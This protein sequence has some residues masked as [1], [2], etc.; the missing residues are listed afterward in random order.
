MDEYDEVIAQYSDNLSL[1]SIVYDV[2]FAHGATKEYVAYLLYRILIPQLMV[3]EI[4][5]LVW[6]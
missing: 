4:R 2:E 1:I 3:M 6:N 5:S